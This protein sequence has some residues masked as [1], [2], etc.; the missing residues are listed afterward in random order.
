MFVGI[1]SFFSLMRATMPAPRHSHSCGLRCPLRALV[2]IAFG[3]LSRDLSR[4]TSSTMADEARSQRAAALEEKKRRLEELKSR[5][6]RRDTEPAAVKASSANLDEYIDGLLKTT[7]PATDVEQPKPAEADAPELVSEIPSTNGEATTT[8]ASTTSNNVIAVSAPPPPVK[9][10]ETFA[11]ATQTEEDDFP[12]GSEQD[13]E[14]TPEVNEKQA[15]TVDASEGKEAEDEQIAVPKI[16]TAEETEEQVSSEPFSSFLNTASKKVE[17]MLGT[18]VLADLLVN[19]VGET[20]GIEST[21]KPADGTRFV[22]AREV[23][24]CAKWTGTRDVTDMDW[25]P[26]H[27]ELM[28]SSYHMPSSHASS[29]GSAALSAVSPD[30]TPSASLAPRSGELQSDGLALVWSLAMP[31]RPEHIFTCGSPVLAARF[32]P[33]EAPL[34]IG[35]CQSGQLV[36]WDV[37][38]G[39]LPV[40]RSSMTTMANSKGHSH[41][42]CAMEIVEGGVSW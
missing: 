32:H 2:G 16:L 40:Q 10:V 3:P 7:A 24:E 39:R 35:G 42:I 8:D 19:Y 26:L 13:E 31:S 12:P 27:R 41:P 5:R 23:Y 36:I 15:E 22:S 9:K 21:D 33:T 25:S 38:A 30:D 11:I 28:L 20:D 17:R 18:A 4:P 34:V 29:L 14:E 1:R 6:N 37:R